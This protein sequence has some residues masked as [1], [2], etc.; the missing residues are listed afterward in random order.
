MITELLAVDFF[1]LLNAFHNLSHDFV[2]DFATV[3]VI[4]CTSFS[5]NSETLWYRKTDFSHFCKVCTLTAEQITHGHV[6]FF[7]HVNPL[8]CHLS[9]LLKLFIAL[10]FLY[11]FLRPKFIA[12][13]NNNSCL[14]S[15][16]R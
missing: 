3:F 15:I 11:S 14:H 5:C 13:I 4:L 16:M 6:A 9:Y 10:I 8:V 1:H 7:K 2:V 12:V